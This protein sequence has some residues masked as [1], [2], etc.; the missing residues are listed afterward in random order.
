MILSPRLAAGKENI[1]NGGSDLQD[2]LVKADTLHAKG[3]WAAVQINSSL[4]SNSQRCFTG[5]AFAA[6]ASLTMPY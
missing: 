4:Y 2:L 3:K 5:D 6:A 1:I